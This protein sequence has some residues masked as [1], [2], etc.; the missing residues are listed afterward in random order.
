MAVA[1][2]VLELGVQPVTSVHVTRLVL[3]LL[4]T[5]ALFQLARQAPQEPG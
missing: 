5:G 1:A 2:K 3:L 4:C